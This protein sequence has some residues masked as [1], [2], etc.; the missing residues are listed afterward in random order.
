MYREL[1]DAL[2]ESFRQPPCIVKDNIVVE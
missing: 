1:I 2:C